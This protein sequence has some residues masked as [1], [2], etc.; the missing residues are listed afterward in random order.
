MGMYIPV[1]E[2]AF[3]KFRKQMQLQF[4][5]GITTVRAYI[6][7]VVKRTGWG[8]WGTGTGLEGPQVRIR[9]TN[10]LLDIPNKLLRA[11]LYNIPPLVKTIIFVGTIFLV[12]GQP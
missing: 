11:T 7:F 6:T 3:T 10:M 2:I 8:T 4:L 1:Q 5:K 9:A 12:A